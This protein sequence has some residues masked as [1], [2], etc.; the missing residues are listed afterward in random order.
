LSDAHGIEGGS[1]DDV[2]PV[3]PIHQYLG[4]PCHADDGVD[5][6]W[7]LPRSRD[8]VGMVGAIEGDGV[9]GPLEKSRGNRFLALKQ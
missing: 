7:V 4:E 9:V 6:E 8:I 2:E 1:V 5:N 3:I